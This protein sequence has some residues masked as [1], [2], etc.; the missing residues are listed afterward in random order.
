[1]NRT[2]LLISF[3][4]ALFF[5]PSVTS[6][7]SP[8]PVKETVLFDFDGGNYDGWT[9]TGDCWDKQPATARTFVD[10]QGNPLVSG[11]VGT[12]YLTTLFKSAATTGKAVSRDFTIDKPFLTF[13]IGGG[14]YPKEACL[15]LVVD[16]KIVR[17]ETGNDSAELRPA[18]WDVYP[19]MGKTA[20]LEVIDAT[21]NPNRGYIMLDDVRLTERPNTKLQSRLEKVMNTVFKKYDI[22]GGVYAVA[23]NGRTE[24]IVSYGVRSLSTN[25]AACID[26]PYAVASIMIATEGTLAAR[27][28]EKGV[29]KWETRFDEIFPEYRNITPVHIRQSTFYDICCYASGIPGGANYDDIR[30]LER[31][32]PPREARLRYMRDYVF[33]MPPVSGGDQHG[34]PTCYT[35]AA[36]LERVT[37]R[38]LKEL[39]QEEMFKPLGM[40]GAGFDVPIDAKGNLFGFGAHEKAPDGTV[41]PIKFKYVNGNGI[42]FTALDFNQFGL[43]HIKASKGQSNYLSAKQFKVGTTIHPNGVWGSCWGNRDPHV[44]T[45]IGNIGG[46]TSYITV[47][48]TRDMVFS[49]YAAINNLE[50]GTDALEEIRQSIL[51]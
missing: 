41:R 6:A 48:V 9:L 47:D 18:Y 21:A 15:N 36:I 44:L 19:L 34:A 39:W 27:M 1:M 35:I 26:D 33:K 7:R 16:G 42:Y 25:E 20:H 29:I 3:V 14:N 13:R 40:R 30:K 50:G 11:I 10:R 24:A 12:G 4:L 23:R 38:T 22:P 43:E 8:T 49:G 17:T 2:A 5:L 32:Y 46:T 28:V 31:S 37:N 45:L 51:R